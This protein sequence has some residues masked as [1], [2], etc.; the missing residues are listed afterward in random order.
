M[1]CVLVSVDK[2]TQGLREEFNEKTEQTQTNINTLVPSLYQCVE[3]FSIEVFWLLSESLLR[4][5]DLVGQHLLSNVLR[6]FL[7]PVV[8]RFTRQTLPTVNRKH[9]F[10]NILFIESFCPQKKRTPERCSSVVCFATTIAISLMKS[11]SEYAHGRLLPRL[12]WSWTVLLP[13]GTHRRP[14]TS[15]TTILLPFMNYLLTLPLN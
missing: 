2:R 3:T 1:E 12:S 6:E 11:A 7:V 14:I 15:I 9:F 4:Q 8:N 10:M 5:G 13:I